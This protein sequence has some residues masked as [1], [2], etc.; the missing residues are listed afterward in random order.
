LPERLRRMVTTGRLI[1]AGIGLA[2]VLGIAIVDREAPG[3]L[4]LTPQPRPVSNLVNS[5]A[6]EARQSM[7]QLFVTRS[8]SDL[9]A[10]AAEASRIGE[11]AATARNRVYR[12]QP[13]TPGVTSAKLLPVPS[14]GENM[15]SIVVYRGA[16]PDARF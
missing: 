7:A 15:D 5:S 12:V 3:F 6:A 16:G 10:Q 8:G 11:A 1:A 13:L 14:A 9:S 2:F 4:R